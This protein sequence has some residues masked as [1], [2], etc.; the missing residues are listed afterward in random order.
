MILKMITNIPEKDNS[1]IFIENIEKLGPT[2]EIEADNKRDLEN[3]LKTKQNI[4]PLLILLQNINRG[5]K[6]LEDINAKLVLK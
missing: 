2:I 3:L 4:E 6:C 5:Y 1:S